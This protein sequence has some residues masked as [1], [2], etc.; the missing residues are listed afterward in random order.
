[1]KSLDHISVQDLKGVGPAIVERLAKLGVTT[2][3][4]ILFHLPLRYQDRTRVVPLRDLREGDDVVI[5]GIV[6]STQVKFGKKRQLVVNLMEGNTG[7]ELRFFYF[8][9]AQQQ[10]FKSGTRVR[11]F[12]EVRRFKG[13]FTMMHPEYRLLQA[14]TPLPVDETLRAIY[15][16]TEGL[17]QVKWQQLTTQALDLLA[18]QSSVIE[19]LP[20]NLNFLP[21]SDALQYVHRPPPEASVALLLDG[22]HPAQQRLAFEELLAHHLSLRQLRSQYQQHLAPRLKIDKDALQLFLN[23][24]GFNLT[25]AQKKVWGE[26]ESD[27][28]KPEAMLRLVQGDVGCGK[29]AI[30]ALAAL[31]AVKNGYQVAVMAPTEL[32]AEQHFQQFQIWFQAL[33]I[34]VE[35]LTG[36]LKTKARRDVLENTALGLSEIVVGTHALFQKAVQFKKLGLVIIDEQHR[37]GVEQRL[38]L[39]EK[40]QYIVDE[41]AI[42]PHQLLLTATPI[43]RSL[44]MVSYA[45]LDISIVDELPPGRIPITTIAINNERREEI[46]ERV[47]KLCMA[48]GQ[49][50]WVCPLI[51]ESENFDYEAAE[52]TVA[53]LTVQLPDLSIALVHGRLSSA[54]KEAVMQRFKSGEIQLLVA[55][56]VIEVGVNVPNASLM[57][58]ENAERLGLSQLHQLRGRVGRG[59]K[60]SYAVLLYQAPLSPIAEQRLGIMRATQDGFVIAQKD[61]ELRGPGELLGTRQTGDQQYRIANFWRD[62]ELL[63]SVKKIADYIFQKEP[64]K[65][66]LLIKRWLGTNERFVNA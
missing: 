65:I 39:R 19:Y 34:R 45:D 66:V 1:M 62:K 20:S 36:S 58:I 21:L 4:D 3:Q 22:Q 59:A 8:T 15:P 6:V 60:Q 17:A 23:N 9:K 44:A 57:I 53:S 52:K 5:E 41:E 10:G 51:E 18:A 7:I 54:D 33:N 28:T 64:G 13:R 40:G 26:I 32:L 48:G 56:T 63:P 35:S 2:V 16:S 49:V 61:L 31:M 11:C 50:Y 14:E 25:A 24:L 38:S 55:T 42:H 46:I 12:G 29:T 43:P 27:L 47:Q 37:F 30:A